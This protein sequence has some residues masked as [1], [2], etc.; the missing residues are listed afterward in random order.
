MDP[1]AGV[2]LKSHLPKGT[3]VADKTATSEELPCMLPP[4]AGEPREVRLLVEGALH[5]AF[6]LCNL[7]RRRWLVA[8]GNIS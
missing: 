4:H 1:L 6:T 7:Q 8:R 2:R 5:A 3:N